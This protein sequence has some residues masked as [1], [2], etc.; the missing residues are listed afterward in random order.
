MFNGVVIPATLLAVV[1]LVSVAVTRALL[2]RR[3]R[4]ASGTFHADS[5]SQQ[6]LSTHK[7]D[8]SS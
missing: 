3:G 8:E 1:L 7:Q 4:V 5:V 6:W 2:R